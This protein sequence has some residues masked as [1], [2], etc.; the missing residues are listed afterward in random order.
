MQ[1]AN[2][3]KRRYRLTSAVDG[4]S[5]KPTSAQSTPLGVA[6]ATRLFLLYRT[7]KEIKIFL[8]NGVY[9]TLGASFV[10]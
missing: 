6:L 4:I 9:F 8:I 3:T 2:K 5:L 1:M 10:L 7:I